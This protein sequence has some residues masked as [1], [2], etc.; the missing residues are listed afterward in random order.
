MDNLI[1]PVAAPG[2]D[3]ARAR[4]LLSRSH[5]TAIDVW[6]GLTGQ[7]LGDPSSPMVFDHQQ[8]MIEAC[9]AG[10]GV[11]V[12]QRPLVETDLASG[13]LIAPHGFTTDGAVFAV[14]HRP[15]PPAAVRRFLVWLQ[16]Q[17]GYSTA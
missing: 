17:G 12:T 15:D 14:F 3:P 2:V 4:Q 8:T 1:G 10:L 9:L 7:P 6:T 5:P 13:R 16:T 11:C